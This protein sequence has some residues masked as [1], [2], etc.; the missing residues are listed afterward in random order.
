MPTK[1]ERWDERYAARP[2]LWSSEPN[3]TVR[4][5]TAALA[6]GRALDLACGEGRNALWLAERG[7][8]V[9]GVDFS[10][11]A[12]ERGR[13]R[14]MARGL[15][16]EWVLGDVAEWKPDGQVDLVVVAFLHTDITAR[17]HWM[18]IARESVAPGGTFLYVGHDLT[19]IEHGSGGPRDPGVLSRP[20]EIAAALPGFEIARA[21]VV[22]REVTGEP[23][24]GPGSG[25]ALDAVVVARRQSA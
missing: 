19:N 10:R 17:Q 1:Q 22:R 24:H 9:T 12:I 13:E 2:L 15:S 16:I 18:S 7:W 3:F 11:V 6:P 25:F 20:E 21:E 8:S 14:A 5:E 4:L 23:G